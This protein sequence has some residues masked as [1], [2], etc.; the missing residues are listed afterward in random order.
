MMNRELKMKNTNLA[1]AL[2]TAF[3]A[4]SGTL[5]QSQEQP[6]YTPIAGAFQGLGN[7]PNG[8]KYYAF[9][10]HDNLRGQDIL[11]SGVKLTKPDDA[12][13]EDLEF[14]TT[15]QTLAN[16]WIAASS[17]QNSENVQYYGSCIAID[18]NDVVLNE[19]TV[20]LTGL[21]KSLTVPVLADDPGASIT[22]DHFWNFQLQMMEEEFPDLFATLE[23]L[24]GAFTLDYEHPDFPA[25]QKRA[26]EY[27]MENT[28]G[29][30]PERSCDNAA[31]IFSDGMQVIY[32]PET[33][34]GEIPVCENI[35]P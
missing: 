35:Y 5:A 15:S 2:A 26:Q 24:G 10:V 16:L 17:P 12:K 22:A 11:C 34:T 33:F 14:R 31:Y 23:N 19:V 18:R 8:A 9:Q 21:Q 20:S 25:F 1:I 30:D 4:A 29:I 3:L 13:F 32:S 7:G 6:R 28:F 27:F